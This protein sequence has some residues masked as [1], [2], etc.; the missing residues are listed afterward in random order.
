MLQEKCKKLR[1]ALKKELKLNN[2]MQV[3]AIEKVVLSTCI[4]EAL[5]NPKILDHALK[6]LTH[7]AGQKVAL[8]R[9][10]KAVAQF[11]TRKGIAL[12]GFVTLRR[13]YMWSFLERLVH[14]A[15]PRVRDFKGLSPKSFDGHGNYNLGIKEQ[16]VFPEVN[17]DKVDA[18]RGFNINIHT[19]AEDDKTAL[20]FLKK[21]GFP[22]RK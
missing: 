11:K 22:F 8:R 4:G 19:T 9:A 10:R 1:P 15:L 21:L 14:F 13:Q 20:L 6:D 16:I 7:I 12:G 3:P 17:Y 18:I 2:I 5:K